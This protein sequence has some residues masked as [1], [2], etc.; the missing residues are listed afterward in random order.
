MC[1]IFDWVF[2]SVSVEQAPQNH[3]QDPNQFNQN[4]DE[5][6]AHDIMIQF[7]ISSGIGIWNMA[8]VHP[9]LPR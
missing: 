9:C 3:V 2:D 4:E 6:D 5:D 1:K 8:H 7:L